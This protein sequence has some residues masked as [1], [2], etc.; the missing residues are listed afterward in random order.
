[1]ARPGQ[2][3]HWLPPTSQGRDLHRCK[4]PMHYRWP[5]QKWQSVQ[6]CIMTV[7]SVD[8]ISCFTER[9]AS[10]DRGALVLFCALRTTIGGRG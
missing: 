6:V 7:T 5:V 9:S 8:L 10:S 2:P 4:Q 1:M 3:D